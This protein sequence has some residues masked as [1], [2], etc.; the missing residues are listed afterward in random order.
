MTTGVS[1]AYTNQW[2]FS[3]IIVYEETPEDSEKGTAKPDASAE[4]E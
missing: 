1:E 3:I 2:E 4:A